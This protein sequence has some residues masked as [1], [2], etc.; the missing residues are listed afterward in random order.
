MEVVRLTGDYLGEFQ[1]LYIE[2]F[3]ELR[4][5]QGWR[6]GEEEAYRKEAES[7]FKRGDLILLA[8]EG[9]LE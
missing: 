9:W 5:K 7:Y 1:T 8:L 3:M 6:A 2:F 4:G